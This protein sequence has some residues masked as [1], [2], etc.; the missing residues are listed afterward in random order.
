MEKRNEAPARMA[1]HPGSIL[2]EEI[3]ERG[4]KQRELAQQMGIQASHLSEIIRGKRPVN[5]SIADKLERVLGLPSINWMRLQLAYEYDMIGLPRE[6]GVIE[7][8]HPGKILKV[9]LAHRGISVS[10]L[11]TKM[12][13]PPGRL[14]EL[15]AEKCRLEAGLAMM[16]EAAIGTNASW[17]LSLQNEYD[18]FM[19]ERDASFMEKLRHI[20]QIAAA[21]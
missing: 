17:L 1:I 19:A 8:V 3:R 21:L 14:D 13:I 16:L 18:M 11:E 20:R 7:P 2:K 4:I 5:K 15:L 12:G 6:S 9:E 10:E